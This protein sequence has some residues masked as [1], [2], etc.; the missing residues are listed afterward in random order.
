[1]PTLV[2]RHCDSTAVIM[3]ESR[4]HIPYLTCISCGNLW[5]KGSH[6]NPKYHFRLD[7]EN[8]KEEVQ[9]FTGKVIELFEWAGENRKWKWRRTS[10]RAGPSLKAFRISR[11]YGMR[12]GQWRFARRIGYSP[13]PYNQAEL[14]NLGADNV[15]DAIC[16]TFKVTREEVLAMGGRDECQP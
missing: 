2:C 13:A 6:S 3:S 7:T 5:E 15:I 4:L 11:G 16:D 12:G 9:R 10:F 8:P 14:G 1:M